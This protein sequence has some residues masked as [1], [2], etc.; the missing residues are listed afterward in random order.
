MRRIMVTLFGVVGCLMMFGANAAETG[1][2]SSSEKK[3][4]EYGWDVPTPDFIV[5]HIREMEQRPFDGLIFRLQGGNNVFDPVSGDEARYQKD[6]EALPKIEWKTFTDNFVIMLAASNQDWF[7]DEHWT[8]IEHNA[9]LIAKA[10]RL[11]HCVGI[12]FDAEP[13]G[14]NPWAY[15]KTAHRDTKSFAEYNTIVRKRG[16]QF[17]RA[18]EQELPNP[19]VLTFFL[20]SYFMKLCVPMADELRD[21]R[22]SKEYYAL[23]PAFLEG[24]LESSGTG[25]EFIDGN[26]EAYYYT[27]SLQYF[28]IYHGV[29]QRARNIIDPKYWALYCAKT[30]MGQALYMDQYYGLRA[31]EKTYGNYLTPEGQQKW[32]EHNAY[33]ALYTADKY[34]WCYSERLNWWTNKDVPEGSEQALRSARTAIA[35]G[36]SLKGDIQPLIEEAKQREKT[37]A[38]NRLV[39][40]TTD[41]TAIPEGAVRPAIDGDLSDAVWKSN[42]SLEAFV[43]LL[44]RGKDAKIEAQTE[45]R[46]LCDEKAIYLSFLCHEPKMDHLKSGTDQNDDVSI[47]L[48]DVVEVFVTAQKGENQFYHFAVNP[49]G[50]AWSGLHEGTKTEPY[51]TAWEHA[52]RIGKDSWTVEMAIPWNALG[53]KTLSPGLALRA[54]FGR[55]RFQNGELSTWRSMNKTFLEPENF[56]QWF[57]P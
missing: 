51:A 36:R 52:A 7:N 18:V 39:R 40:R 29:S 38:G 14:D 45:V 2:V 26:E 41:V 3:L 16:A 25:T 12:C 48:G 9:R 55:E 15:S 56:G 23:L 17:I 8:A 22:L 20:T 10:A 37:D 21:E 33:W 54:N 47:F 6:Y 43:P 31:T 34:V 27:N 42:P 30:R 53:Y 5:S 46:M 19:K 1:N 35:T 28:E 24:M 13:Y 44:G 11:A 32:F 57:L 50:A 4:I 49:K